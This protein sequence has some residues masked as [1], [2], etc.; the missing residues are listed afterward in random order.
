MTIT[1]ATSCPHCC[2]IPPPE[3]DRGK[4]LP[5]PYQRERRVEK[6]DH[7]VG[8]G[9]VDD[10]QAGGGPQAPALDAD[11]ADEDVAEER[12]DDD[13]G[14]RRDQQGF[15]RH[16]LCVHPV[17]APAHEGLPARQRLVIPGK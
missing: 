4:P 14:V 6:R 11:V 9:Q 13:D 15:G 7:D 2:R 12:D 3:K 1:P 17:P 5:P 10:E 16:V 8:H